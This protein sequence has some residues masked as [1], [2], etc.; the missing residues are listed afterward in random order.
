MSFAD[1]HSSRLKMEIENFA[2]TTLEIRKSYKDEFNSNMSSGF[3]LVR[4]AFMILS[5]L[6][7]ARI[8]AMGAYC[9]LSI[10]MAI[11]NLKEET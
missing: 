7:D 8:F 4:G 5:S 6:K 2:S 1:I 3:K 9:I 11:F 10:G